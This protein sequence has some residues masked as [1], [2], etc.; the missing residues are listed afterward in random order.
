MF[1]ILGGDGKEY[2]PVTA[3]QVRAWIAAGRANLDT[4]AKAIGSEEWRRLADFAEFS[5]DTI[6][7]PP[8]GRSHDAHGSGTT[9]APGTTVFTA[10]TGTELELAGRGTRLAGAIIDQAIA[11]VCV[12]PGVLMMGPA[13]M[14]IM[15][16][17]GRG[18]EPTF[19]DFNAAGFLFGAFVAFLGWLAQ[20][21]VQIWMLS[22]RGQ[23]IAKRLLNIRI[24]MFQDNG[25][26]GFVH[27]WLLR[28]FVPAI[29]SFV[30]YLGF[31]FV[32]V[33]ACFIFGEQRR[34]IHDHIAGTKV[35]KA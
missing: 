28:N 24:V 32:I 29:I 9:L 31:I 1:T 2:G 5:P 18:E 25:Q 26:P 30:P 20:L 14:E 15:L 23:S 11:A 4:Q 22:T 6:T 3:D 35:V 12:L 8:L 10:R 17:A 34:C 19:E 27:A 13:F 21:S 33:N 7:P 16:A